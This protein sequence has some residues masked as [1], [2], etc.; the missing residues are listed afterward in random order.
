MTTL[1][2]TYFK[3]RLKLERPLKTERPLRVTITFDEEPKM[4]LQI[5][6]FS[7]IESQEELKHYEGSFSNEVIEERRQAL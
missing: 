5:S 2:G 6:D 4:R 1:T 7:F 3:G